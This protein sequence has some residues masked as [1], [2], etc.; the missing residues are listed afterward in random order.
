MPVQE[1][2]TYPE[3]SGSRFEPRRIQ[4]LTFL[5]CKIPV[6]EYQL[7]IWSEKDTLY[8]NDLKESEIEQFI[9][10]IES[11]KRFLNNR[12]MD[13]IYNKYGFAVYMEIR[14][15]HDYFLK[16]AD[17]ALAEK[18]VQEYMPIIEKA[19]NKPSIPSEYFTFR[20]PSVRF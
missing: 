12:T 13:S 20:E 14:E 6:A 2:A 1:V 10:L 9:S 5:F 19:M 17:E 15:A 16:N 8:Y 3:F 11:E 4:P 18:I 7:A